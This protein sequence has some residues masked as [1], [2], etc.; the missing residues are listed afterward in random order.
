[1]AGKTEF[2]FAEERTPAV[3]VFVHIPKTAGTALRRFVRANLAAGRDVVQNVRSEARTPGEKIAWFREWYRS[4]DED[5]RDRL[6]CVMSH[7]AGYLLPALD[8]EVDA[9]TL[10]REPVDRT[11]SYYF[12]KQRQFEQREQ[13]EWSLDSLERLAEKRGSP[14][15]RRGPSRRRPRSLPAVHGIARPPVRLAESGRSACEGESTTA[16]RRNRL[17]RN[18]GRRSSTTTG[19]PGS[20][21]SYPGK[22]SWRPSRPPPASSVGPAEGR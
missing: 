21:T 2:F 4:L 15:C 9:L 17:A 3:I 18:S 7:E 20:S 5:R 1:V 10:V 22:R 11:L 14:G 19:S 13:P 6:S 12:F 16:R 8:R